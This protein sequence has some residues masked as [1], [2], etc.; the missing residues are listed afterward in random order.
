MSY[1]APALGR[2]DAVPQW[3]SGRAGLC[4][5]ARGQ[6]V[7]LF[8]GIRAGAHQVG[9]GLRQDVRFAVAE[10]HR[11]KTISLPVAKRCPP[12]LGS[13]ISGF[14]RASLPDLGASASQVRPCAHQDA[15]SVVARVRSKT[16]LLRSDVSGLPRT[17]LPDLAASA[18]HIGLCAHRDAR[19]AAAGDLR[20]KTI[21]LPVKPQP[22]LDRSTSRCSSTCAGSE[23]TGDDYSDADS[24][25]DASP[26]AI[27]IAFDSSQHAHALHDLRM[28]LA[29]LK[30]KLQDLH[31]PHGIAPASQSF[32]GRVQVWKALTDLVRRLHGFTSDLGEDAVELW[33]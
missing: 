29:C 26:R 21:T 4:S 9:H 25:Q 8:L 14:P 6:P 30:A 24:K 23:E 15:H 28:E 20:R 22:S 33:A 5:D 19:C 13:D 10:D 17:L 2:G 18:N 1:Q 11:R 32:D 3:Y 27:C 16:T 7:Q 31:L 12:R